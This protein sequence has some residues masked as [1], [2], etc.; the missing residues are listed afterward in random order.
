MKEQIELL[1]TNLLDDSLAPGET[2]P[3]GTSYDS[4]KTVASKASREINDLPRE[5]FSVLK[6]IIESE[7]N[8]ERRSKAYSI[9]SRLASIFED[10]DIVHYIIGK[11]G[12]EK[13]KNL[14]S[15]YLDS[16]AWSKIKLSD[17]LDVVL[18]FL[19]RKEWQIRHAAI[20]LL[21]NYEVGK[22]QIELALIEILKTSKDHY[23]LLYAN[24]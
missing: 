12:S 15:L 5:S 13:D 11:L 10:R 19:N 18:E 9:L 24:S 2:L 20:R 14:I 6:S 21:G 4:S 3:Q 23:D 17:K 8:K 22:E 7:K 1:I 16:T